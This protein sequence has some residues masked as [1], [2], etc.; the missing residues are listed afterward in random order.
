MSSYSVDQIIGKTLYAKKKTP[1]YNLPSFYSNAKK[2]TTIQ[3]GQIIGTVYSYVGGSPDQPLNWMYKTKVGLQE[4]TYYTQHEDNNVDKNALVDQ[5]TKTTQEIEREKAEANKSTTE[6][7]LDYL[8]K[9]ALYA[10]VAY[11]VYIFFIKNK[12]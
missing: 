3:P 9:Y 7:L 2:V 4:V 12:K 5:G 1:V 6:K 11:G 10:G 8:K